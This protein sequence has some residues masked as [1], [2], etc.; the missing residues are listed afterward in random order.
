[1]LVY[2]LRGCL[3]WQGIKQSTKLATIIKMGE[4]KKQTPAAELCKGLPGMAS[5]YSDE[6]SKFLLAVRSL[7]F[8]EEPPYDALRDIFLK[9]NPSI[10]EVGWDW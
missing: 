5:G 7:K 1:M 3:P 4:L 2:F 6:I 8:E 9:R 10:Q